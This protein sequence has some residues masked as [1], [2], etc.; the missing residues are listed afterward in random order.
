MITFYSTCRKLKFAGFLL[1]I[2]SGL[3]MS[4]QTVRY[5]KQGGTGDG[6]SWANATGNLQSAINSSSSGWHLYVAAGT[7]Q[8]A[9]GQSFS[10]KEGVKI[11]GGFAATGNPA[12]A[13][14]NW[15]A[16]ITVLLG[17]NAA[18]IVNDNNGVTNAAL[19]DG[20]TITNGYGGQGGGMFSHNTSPTLTNLIVKNNYA[21]AEGGGLYFNNGSP[22][23][24]NVAITGNI[25]GTT[26]SAARRGGG[27]YAYD[28]FPALTNVL[29]ANNTI[30]GTGGLGG[31][32]SLLNS[33]PSILNVTVA[34]NTAATGAGFYSQ[35]GTP[36]I[37]NSIIYNN[38]VTINGGTPAWYNSIVQGSGGSAAW[39]GNFGTNNGGNLDT[40]AIFINAAGADYRLSGTSPARNTGNTSLFANAAASIDLS[41]QPRL[42]GAAIDMGAYEHQSDPP[43]A[44]A[45]NFCGTTT[46]ASLL[47]TGTDLKWYSAL[48]G[49]AALAAN[50]AVA[51]DTYY[52]SQTLNGYES[53]RTTISV[54]VNSVPAAPAASAQ[55]FCGPATV[56]DLVADGASITWYSQAEG[57]EVLLQSEVLTNG[58]YYASQTVMCEGPRT[59]VAVSTYTP[60]PSAPSDQVFN[61]PVT[62]ADISA[63]GTDLKWYTSSSGG[64]PVASS[65]QLSTGTYF[66]SQT[67]NGCESARTGIK[68]YL[69][70]SDILFVKKNATGT[71]TSWE[72]AIGELGNALHFA[73][74][75]NA[76]APGTITQVWVAGGTYKPVPTNGSFVLLDTV[77]LYGH[78][79]GNETSVAQ[80]DL[81]NPAAQTVLS[82]DINDNDTYDANDRPLDMYGDNSTY[83]I[84][85]G[86]QGGSATVDGFT[87][88]NASLSGVRVQ[89][90]AIQIRNCTLKHNKD[91]GIFMRYSEGSE[92]TNVKILSNTAFNHGSGLYCEQGNGLKLTNVLVANNDTSIYGVGAVMIA[93]M[94]NVE[95]VNSTF[96][97]NSGMGEYSFYGYNSS[98][99]MINS[100]IAGNF[101]TLEP[102]TF[103][104]CLLPPEFGNNGGDTFGADP[105]FTNAA[106]L[107][108]TL[109]QG[110]PAINA[111]NTSYFNNAATATDLAGNERLYGPAVDMGAYEYKLMV[112]GMTTAWNGTEWSNGTPVSYEYSAVINGD[113]N[114]TENG[115]I[116]A[117][118][119]TVNSGDVVIAEG[120]NFTIKGAVTVDNNNAT[121]TIQHNANLIQSD[122][123][124]NVGTISV[125]KESAPMY[126]LDYALWASP[127]AWQKLKAFSQQTLDNRFYTYN[128]LSDAY[129]TIQSPATTDFAEGKS[130]LIR[131]S[132]SHPAYV[133]DAIAP[134][135]WTGNFIGVPNNGNVDV[136]VTGMAD[137]INGFNG[138]GNPYPSSIN[139]AAFFEANQ[140]NLA[141]DTPIYFWRKKND[142][143]TSSY[144][145]LTLAGYNKNSGNVFGDSSNGVFDNPDDSENW[146]INS[147]QGFIVQATGS[148]VA[149]NNE[150]RV[151]MN[152]GQMFRSAMD[153]SDKS[154]LWLN[155]SNA[156]GAFGQATIAYTP[157]TTL[158]RDFSWDGKALTDG[159]IA[160]YSLAGENK[161]AIQAR[162][163]F[164]ASDEVPMEYKITTAGNY[165]I[166]LDH[167]DGVFT[168][169]Q[170]IYLRDN[171]L[172]VIH[173][174]VNPYEFTTDAGIITGRFDVVYA[175]ALH[176]DIPEF[177]ANSIIVYKQ[178]NAINISSGNSDMES[179][180]VYDVRGRLLYRTGN[181]ND[182]RTS[183]TTLQAEEQMLIIQVSTVGGVKAS[184]KIIF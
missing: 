112:C 111:G 25:L 141:E 78:F 63:Q 39:N 142:E 150:M 132:N 27:L 168:Q 148:T 18:V 77:K 13:D 14:R 82:G 149:F 75:V 38:A 79:I 125:I 57:G 161:F 89:Q 32:L 164:D 74:D 10:M 54:T 94:N 129:A 71:G 17:N 119:L 118:S 123:V 184:R 105:L 30:L 24:T 20:F 99:V 147:G 133:S 37:K 175:E 1:I 12:F 97:Y 146:V 154:R 96:G 58:T 152:N 88:S 109:Q 60:P 165:T 160:I 138:I 3:T 8:P 23:L 143:N 21:S 158:G 127:V 167:F 73:M 62:F 162:P 135:P 22:V 33:S 70:M 108:Y 157:F 181:I 47:A 52:V 2:F 124:D 61:T 102:M 45:Q 107:D 180:A 179:V 40:D 178:G 11:Y 59:A 6:T 98:I 29:V 121:F 43:T 67:L 174:L 104:N 120:D 66:V 41:G 106:N 116:T 183:I 91:R 166:S 122:D 84:Y 103:V 114:S 163:A 159:E 53:S 177:N 81:T 31:G 144:A 83:V 35:N 137:G 51:S 48:T 171:V 69:V 28:S 55:N 5:V 87:I 64:T 68:V 100:I 46:V 95:I 173:N 4:S 110:S 93:S 136:P 76:I 182:S 153:A 16:N 34:G 92:L 170:E 113:Y 26:D 176:T 169:G 44:Q 140:N 90:M 50:S 42:Y 19:L 130:Y 131:V 115:N 86:I 49:G 85:A 145:S 117:C 72:D 101:Q 7:Y 65:L 36:Q 155:L 56:A 139:I 128:P 80:R 151:A 134:T 156:N 9:S 126:R 172:G 15:T